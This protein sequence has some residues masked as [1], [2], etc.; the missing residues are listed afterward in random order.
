[1]LYPQFVNCLFIVKTIND[2][3]GRVKT[4]LSKLVIT[5]KTERRVSRHAKQKGNCAANC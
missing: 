2:W 4:A 3:T 1:M 5:A